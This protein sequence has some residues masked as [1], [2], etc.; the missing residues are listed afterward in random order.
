M[1]QRF[2]RY[3]IDRS[4]C[5][6]TSSSQISSNFLG[7]PANSSWEPGHPV[8]CN[9]NAGADGAAGVRHSPDS[10]TPLRKEAGAILVSLHNSSP[11]R[12][13]SPVVTV[14]VKTLPDPVNCCRIRCVGADSSLNLNNAH[15]EHCKPEWSDSSLLFPVL[16][17][18]M[19]FGAVVEVCKEM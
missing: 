4:A 6:G 9:R 1:L 13:P 14:L 19:S 3:G 11:G 5:L 16:S 2:G 12:N 17:T 10:S 15:T 7:R 18:V 8:P